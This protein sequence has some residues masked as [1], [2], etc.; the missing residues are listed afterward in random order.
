MFISLKSLKACTAHVS[1]WLI[2]H[3]TRNMEGVNVPC[4]SVLGLFGFRKVTYT[5]RRREHDVSDA[6]GETAER[7]CNL[8][9]GRGSQPRRGES[10]G[11]HHGK[12]RVDDFSHQGAVGFTGG[13]ILT[14]CRRA[15][16]HQSKIKNPVAPAPVNQKLKN[17]AAPKHHSNTVVDI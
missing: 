16:S 1:Y 15:C 2:C 9:E 3:K 5:P 17:L 12:T 6:G 4:L 13:V 8:R 11:F 7:Q 14:N 10:F